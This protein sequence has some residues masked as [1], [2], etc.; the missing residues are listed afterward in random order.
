MAE[1]S[2]R[3]LAALLIVAIIVSLGGTLISLQKIKSM[4]FVPIT[5]FAL[6]P[7]YGYVNLTVES[8]AGLDFTDAYARIDFG[9]GYVEAGET[10]RACTM[11][12]NGTIT[13]PEWWNSTYCRDEWNKTW[14][15]GETPLELVNIGTTYLNV[16]IQSNETASQYL[17]TQASGGTRLK[18]WF[19]DNETG[20]CNDSVTLGSWN[21]VTTTK[22]QVCQC[23]NFTVSKNSLAIGAYV[24][25][26]SDIDPDLLDKETKVTWTATAV[27]LGATA[28]C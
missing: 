17:P 10:T 5:G 26:T 12:I 11:W 22:Q 7:T 19:Q 18:W 8:V 3:V 9:T 2:N 27:D 16:S 1:V 20:S 13:S 23:L 21:D 24:N 28:S 25:I 6:G 15:T 4:K 14:A